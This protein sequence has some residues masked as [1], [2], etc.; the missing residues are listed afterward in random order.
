MDF[1]K[2]IELKNYGGAYRRRGAAKENLRDYMGALSDYSKA[3]ELNPIR[4]DSYRKR[5]K[6]KGI[7]KDYKG[8]ISDF[9]K[10]IKCHFMPRTYTYIAR[11]Y[12]DRGVMKL[13]LGNNDEACIDFYKADELGNNSYHEAAEAIKEKCD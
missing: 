3:V 4:S 5:G 6:L 13:K 10:A 9:S 12:Y 2:F 11:I 8:A 7:L 1:T